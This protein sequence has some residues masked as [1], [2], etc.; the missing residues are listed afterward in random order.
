MIRAAHLP[1]SAELLLWLIPS[2]LY[3]NLQRLAGSPQSL[4]IV[5]S[6]AA[7][8]LSALVPKVFPLNFRTTYLLALQ[9]L[10]KA[11]ET[12]HVKSEVII[13]SPELCITSYSLSLNFTTLHCPWQ[14]S[15]PLNFP[16]ALPP[17]SVS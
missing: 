2:E 1:P 12:S 5:V 3:I 9:S 14:K 7:S 4:A 16:S 11:T 6:Q 17:T 13:L 15:G 10:H 8:L